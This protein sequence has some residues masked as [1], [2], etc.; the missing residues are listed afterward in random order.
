MAVIAGDLRL[1]HLL[2]VSLGV[3]GVLLLPGPAGPKLI[4]ERSVGTAAESM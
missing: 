2:E 1:G 4:P 3:A